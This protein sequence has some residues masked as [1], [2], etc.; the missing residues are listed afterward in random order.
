MPCGCTVFVVVVAA[1]INSSS[2]LII[3]IIPPCTIDVKFDHKEQCGRAGSSFVRL[4]SFSFPPQ[5]V[6]HP[7]PSNRA[8][9]D[10]WL[11]AD[12]LQAMH[13]LYPKEVVF[14]S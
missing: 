3:A 2:V 10:C 8:H 4:A 13:L 6:H 9:G 7:I 12:Y 11:D 1:S 14:D 5:S